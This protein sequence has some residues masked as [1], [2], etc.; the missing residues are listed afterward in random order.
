MGLSLRDERFVGLGEDLCI[1]VLQMGVT[2]N[3]GE[4]EVQVV[5]T[6]QLNDQRGVHEGTLAR[7]FG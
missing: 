2:D 5:A 4:L 7:L 1:P 6:R 3:S